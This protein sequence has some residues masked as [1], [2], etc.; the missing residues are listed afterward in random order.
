MY[1][2]IHF[3]LPQMHWTRKAT[4]NIKDNWKSQLVLDVKSVAFVPNA[5]K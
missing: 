5:A 2:E 3:Y 1:V 4:V